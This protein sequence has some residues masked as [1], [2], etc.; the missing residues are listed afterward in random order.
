MWPKH[1][2]DDASGRKT[3][4]TRAFGFSSIPLDELLARRL[5]EGGTQMNIRHA[6]FIAGYADIRQLPRRRLPEIAFAGRSNVGKSSLI[7][8]LLQRK[9]L[10]RTSGTPGKTRQLNYILVNEKL[11]FVD[12]PGYGFAKVSQSERERWR[13][14]IESYLLDNPVLRVVVCIIDARHGPA[15]SDVQL[16]TWLAENRIPALVVATKVD[17][18]NRRERQ[19]AEKRIV[20]SIGKLPVGGPVF[21]SSTSGEGKRE[22]LRSL[23]L[24][25]E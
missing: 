11:Y 21:F 4:A 13:R 18:L 9:N 8:R 16:F 7:N 24:Y 25:L 17:K 3:G 19:Q 6:E 14:L 2:L 22:L 23:E 10:A 5:P 15:P 1:S 20:E 12:M